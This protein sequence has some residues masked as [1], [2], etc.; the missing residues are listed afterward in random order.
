LAGVVERLVGFVAEV[1]R[2]LQIEVEAGYDLSRWGDSMKL[3]HALQVQA[4]ALIDLA[5]VACALLGLQSSTYVDA[6]RKLLGEGLL[7]VEDFND[8]KKIVGFRNVVVH[9]YLAVNLS[10]GDEVLR[11]RKFFKA[12]ELAEKLWRGLKERGIDP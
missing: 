6:G 12:V 9:A 7:G 11:E 2:N 8:Y 10:I 5:Q 4:Q 1:A 3:L